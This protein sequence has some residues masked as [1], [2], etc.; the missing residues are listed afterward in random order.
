M[1][2]QYNKKRMYRS[3][4]RVIGGVLGGF[5]KYINYDPTIVRI[6]Y[7]ILS[8]VSAAFPGTL[9]YIILWAITPEE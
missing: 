5:A 8:I 7:V 6:L 1:N 9:V 3:R 2:S 4:D